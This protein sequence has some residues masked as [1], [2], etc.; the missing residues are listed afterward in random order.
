MRS[1]TVKDTTKLVRDKLSESGSPNILN[2]IPVR[3]DKKL[4]MVRIQTI[5]ELILKL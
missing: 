1:Q 3:N 2:E 5:R 4:V